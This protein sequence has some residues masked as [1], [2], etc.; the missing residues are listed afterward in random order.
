MLIESLKFCMNSN[1]QK[2]TLKGILQQTLCFQGEQYE[3]KPAGT[4]LFSF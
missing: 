3:R 2:Q 4:N 1:M